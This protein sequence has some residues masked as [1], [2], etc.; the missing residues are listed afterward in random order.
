MD[1]GARA[2]QEYVAEKFHLLERNAL[3]KLSWMIIF[4]LK[5]FRYLLN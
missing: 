2:T 1:A 4:G 5:E 3:Q